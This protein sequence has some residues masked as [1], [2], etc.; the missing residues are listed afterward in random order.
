VGRMTKR[1]WAARTP[2]ISSADADAFMARCNESHTQQWRVKITR[3]Q[4]GENVTLAD[5]VP[6][7]SGTL[8]L[9]SSDPIRRR[10]SAEIGPGA[11]W[12]PYDKDSALVPFGQFA[13][14]YVRIDLRGGG[15]T[16]W[17][18]VFEGA[19]Q[20]NVYERP[21]QIST[22]EAADAS[23]VVDDFLYLKRRSY[24]KGRTLKS[25]LKEIVDDA[26][27]GAIYEVDASEKSEDT[28]LGKAFHVEAGES[29]WEAANKLAGKHDQ[30]CFFDGL[31]A[32]CVRK[33]IS[34]EDDDDWDPSEPGPDI[35]K[36]SDPIAKFKDGEGG[37][38]IGVSATIS[39]EGAVNAVAI[40]VSATVNHRKKGAKKAVS[41]ELWYSTRQ[42]AGGTVAFGDSFGRKPLVETKSVDKLTAEVKTSAQR[43]AKTLL[44]RRRGLLKYLE[45]DALPMPW[46][47]PDDKVKVSIDGTKEFHYVQSV[48]LDLAGGPMHVRTR[49]LSVTDPGS[50][51][52]PDDEDE[53]WFGDLPTVMKVMVRTGY[54][55]TGD[56]DPI[57]ADYNEWSSGG[58]SYRISSAVGNYG[59]P[60]KYDTPAVWDCAWMHVWEGDRGDVNW[61]NP[62]SDPVYHGSPVCEAPLGRVDSNGGPAIDDEVSWDVSTYSSGGL[63]D[64]HVGTSALSSWLDYNRVK[65]LRV[66]ALGPSAGNTVPTPPSGY[67][68]EWES[69]LPTVTKIEGAVTEA[70]SKVA[71]NAGKIYV[72]KFSGVFGSE[73]GPNP[74]S[75]LTMGW[76]Y[77]RATTGGA[78]TPGYEGGVAP[79]TDI[80]SLIETTGK[81]WFLWVS[82][83]IHDRARHWTN[84]RVPGDAL[85][86]AREGV[87]LA[88][89]FTIKPSR[90]RFVPTGGGG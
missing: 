14:L 34:D 19:I 72:K 69:P 30:D 71:T 83:V 7:V 5:D 74:A 65:T 23:Q 49:T 61:N 39:R 11:D 21:S 67:T 26:L 36:V 44:Q 56:W 6:V 58:A 29:R 82:D 9:D 75:V 3:W 35:G 46:V 22:I 53:G 28:E 78:I 76:S 13:H 18:K 90:Y 1:G 47:E 48:T 41:K 85:G 54:T 77:G 51:P 4:D 27:P 55:T 66:D 33:E 43:R 89:R 63:N 8:T 68:L 80:T 2:T 59:S 25:V 50:P 52:V 37:N 15:W 81:T 10:I 57:S 20:S 88:F 17:Y 87:M 38:L 84:G 79:W 12:V 31:G 60:Y 86:E 24:N 16:P 64:V 45:F 62:P 73:Y 32:F 40:N 42:D 70:N